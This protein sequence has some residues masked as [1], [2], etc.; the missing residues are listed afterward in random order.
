MAKA[1]QL[2]TEIWFGAKVDPSVR[3]ACDNITKAYKSLD[4]AV[5]KTIKGVAMAT[6]AVGAA[7][8]GAL[9]VAVKAGAD[10]EKQMA[11]VATLL[12]GD[13]TKRV[14]EL[15]DQI[16]D[17][18][19]RTK[20][21][22]EDLTN[23]AYQI[24]SAFGDAPDSAEKLEIAAKAAAAGIAETN[25]AVNLFSAQM[26]G[27]GDTS[28]EFM[29]QC[30]DMNFQVVK[31]G[32]TSFPE[33]AASLPKVIPI[34]KMMGMTIQEVNGYMATLTG[35]TGGAAEV[36]TQ[37]SA[38]LTAF[39][40]PTDKMKEKIKAL[41]F[42]DG[43]AMI[44]ARGLQGS[45]ELLRKTV[46]TDVEFGNLF[47]RKEGIN[48][49]L[50]ATGT[51]ADTVREKT[52]A[53]YE[54]SGVMETA[55]AK[56]GDNLVG[57][58]KAITNA[59]ETAQ[60]AIGKKLTP[61]LKELAERALPHVQKWLDTLVM[62]FDEWSKAASEWVR[63]IDFGAIMQSIQG[64]IAKVKEWA[65][66]IYNNSDT[67][68]AWAKWIGV[69]MA[70]IKGISVAIAGVKMVMSVWAFGKSLVM[71]FV[72]AL[73]LAKTALIAVWGGMTKIA[74]F[75]WAAL[76]KSWTALQWAWNAAVTAGK[77]AISGAWQAMLAIKNWGV[78]VKIWT[79][80]QWAWNAA[81][82]ANPIGLIV[83]AIGAAVAAGWW[84]YENWDEVC[85]WC[86]QM[87]QSFADMFPETTKAIEDGWNALCNWFNG[88]WEK[89]CSAV[90]TAWDETCKAASVAGAW[91]GKQWDEVCAGVRAAWGATTAYA[92]EKW[93]E[94]S[95][96]FP[97]AASAM[98]NT[99][100]ATT[101]LFSGDFAGAHDSIVAAWQDVQKVFESSLSKFQEY[102]AKLKDML[103]GV[104]EALKEKVRS[105]IGSIMEYLQPLID[106]VQ[107][108]IELAKDP[109]KAFKNAAGAAWEGTKN[110]ASGAW[111]GVKGMFSS[112]GFTAGPSI[113]GE[114][115]TEAVIS[116][117][118]AY[119]AEN[120]GYLMT[121]AEMLGMTA[122]PS[123]TSRVETRNNTYNLGGITFSPVIRAGSPEAGQ[124]VLSQ[125]KAIIPDLVDAIEAELNKRNATRYA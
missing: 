106:K 74:A 72:G 56:Q 77:V 26:K 32:Q 55:F 21:P 91:L 58:W 15:G 84:L 57:R 105:V 90:S 5:S 24:I 112:G 104:W 123:S 122:T 65:T 82:S 43:Q 75:G 121:A 18:K 124:S 52:K 115:G 83:V 27:Y 80:L 23:G 69:A 89:T 100:A 1:K 79:G 41:G 113:C 36:A 34:A 9:A 120:Q 14:D 73:S 109:G 46:S 119:R 59:V 110:L 81:M 4:S 7:A 63:T 67:I 49:A 95:N 2:K 60:I 103:V 92:S 50:A 16:L 19:K 87:W 48:F 40:K 62:K 33:L 98:N 13:V 11:N 117:D 28:A 22:I 35:V 88:A 99:W 86:K 8:A 118:P 31:L 17:V 114:A 102:A 45:L 68:L 78:W 116:F 107:G 54:A 70:A 12:D 37:M 111:E 97:N 71:G 3:K 101:S 61:V 85:A 30:A 6:A 44:Q 53:M 47:G 64:A 96:N 76:V 20:K 94:F 93:G 38:A 42:A 29:R 39:L 51:L 66:A 108:F 10:F 25:D 125:L